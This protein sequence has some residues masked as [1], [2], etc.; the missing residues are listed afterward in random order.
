MREVSPYFLNVA[1]A[2][3]LLQP[4]LFPCPK[5]AYKRGFYIIR[6]TTNDL[7]INRK[8]RSH[9]VYAIYFPCDCFH[10]SVK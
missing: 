8:R 4:S 2:V 5:H 9:T 6:N 1:L 7:M 3:A 10:F